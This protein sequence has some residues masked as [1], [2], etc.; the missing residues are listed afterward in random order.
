[1]ALR[2]AGSP[3]SDGSAASHVSPCQWGLGRGHGG[4]EE[5]PM[6]VLR[7]ADPLAGGVKRDQAGQSECCHHPNPALV[8][9]AQQV[10]ADQKMQ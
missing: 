7:P 2:E 10:V 1:M 4:E 3:S 5:G 9:F 6:G 8:L